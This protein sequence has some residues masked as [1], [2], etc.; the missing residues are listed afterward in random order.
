MIILAA[1]LDSWFIMHKED[2]LLCSAGF[3]IV[4]QHKPLCVGENCGSSWVGSRPNKMSLNVCVAHFYVIFMWLG[5][6]TLL[7]LALL[8]VVA[9][10][11]VWCGGVCS[12]SNCL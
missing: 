7:T 10:V 8:W 3:S 9:L 2:L 5:N 1:V 12:Q 11:R 4:S 6:K